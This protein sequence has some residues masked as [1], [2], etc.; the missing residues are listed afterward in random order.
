MEHLYSTLS[1]FPPEGPLQGLALYDKT[2]K[3]HLNRLSRLLKENM[4]D[5]VHFG[6][7]L[8]DLLDPAVHSLSYL[9][10]L[11]SLVLPNAAE[12]LDRTVLLEKLVRFLMGFDRVQIRY[13]G[14]HLQDVFT[15]VAIGNLLPVC[16]QR[17]KPEHPP[18]KLDFLLN[19]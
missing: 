12:S 6:P 10:V 19:S 2:A 3:Q 15:A 9:A 16:P 17:L 7:Q 8:L 13:A 18:C 4:A 5:L 1:S 11:H 14:T